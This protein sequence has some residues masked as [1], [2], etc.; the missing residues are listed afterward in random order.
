VLVRVRDN[1][2]GIAPEL[3][4]RVF[5]LFVQDPRPL[6]R[7]DGG[8]G[9]GLAVVRA[10]VQAH[11][12]SVSVSSEGRG[13]GSEFLVELPALV[14]APPVTSYLDSSEPERSS[15][16]VVDDNVDAAD[17]LAESLAWLGHRTYTAYDARSAHEL[18]SELRPSTALLDI[19]LPIVDGYELARRLRAQQGDILLIAVTGYGQ[20]S[21]RD[22]SR[23]AGFDEHLVKPVSVDE[24]SRMVE[25]HLNGDA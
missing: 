25:R 22:R 13:Q 1:G 18:A 5:D 9:A 19:G 3:L 20:P 7:S 4:S 17:L 10:I 24:V 23:A 6:D 12:G 11:Q 8:L 2:V 16:L 21:D 14:A 15:V